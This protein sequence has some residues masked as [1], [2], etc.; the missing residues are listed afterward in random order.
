M[1]AHYSDAFLDDCT[2]YGIMLY[3]VI[4][5]AAHSSNQCQPLDLGIFGAQK[6]AIR[7]VFPNKSLNPQTRQ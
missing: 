6:S 4:F 1:S 7:R 2:Y 3:D 5:L